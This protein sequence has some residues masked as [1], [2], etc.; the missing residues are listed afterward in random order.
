MWVFIIFSWT[1]YQYVWLSS[2]CLASTAVA[3]E[4]T[5]TRSK[6]KAKATTEASAFTSALQPR[7][8]DVAV[9]RNYAAGLFLRRGLKK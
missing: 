6:E 9:L 3:A 7:L 1:R 8:G 4:A 5:S 2:R